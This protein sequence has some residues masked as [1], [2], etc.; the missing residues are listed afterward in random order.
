MSYRNTEMASCRFWERAARRPLRTLEAA[1]SGQL[2][3]VSG[4]RLQP[5][6]VA[7][8]ARLLVARLDIH[9]IGKLGCFLGRPP[10][11]A[12]LPGSVELDDPGAALIEPLLELL[13]DRLLPGPACPR[14]LEPGFDSPSATAM[15]CILALSLNDCAMKALA[16]SAGAALNCRRF[17]RVYT[18]RRGGFPGPRILPRERVH[19]RVARRALQLEDHALGRGEPHSLLSRAGPLR[20]PCLPYRCVIRRPGGSGIG[21]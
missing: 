19:R 5:F 14:L 7:D 6:P 8:P 13:L 3:Q 17:G 16:R 12:G 9:L 10:L 1:A 2:P 4:A 18:I 21:M 20:L 15:T 11:L